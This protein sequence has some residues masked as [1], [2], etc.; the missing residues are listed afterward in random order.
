MMTEP[1]ILFEG[2]VAYAVRRKA[3][4]YEVM[5]YSTNAATHMCVGIKHDEKSAERVV[6]RLNAYPDQARKAHNLL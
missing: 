1:E 4:V 5:I 6:R 2:P 3:D